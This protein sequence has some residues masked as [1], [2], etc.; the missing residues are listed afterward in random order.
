MQSYKSFPNYKVSDHKPVAGEFV[1]K[2]F[3]DYSDNVVE[4]S[5]IKKWIINEENI[6]S[7]AADGIRISDWDWIGIYKVSL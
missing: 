6:V 2:V 3:S 4:F 5:R 7:F 1:F